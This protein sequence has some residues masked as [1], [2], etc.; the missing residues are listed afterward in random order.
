MILCINN[1]TCTVS[2][3]ITILFSSKG[4]RN[5]LT[6]CWSST[7]YQVLTRLIYMPNERLSTITSVTKQVLQS[8]IYVSCSHNYHFIWVIQQT[9]QM[10]SWSII[11][12]CVYIICGYMKFK[13]LSVC[14]YRRKKKKA[15]KHLDLITTT[16]FTT[17]TRDNNHQQLLNQ[18][19]I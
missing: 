12:G 13:I 15:K 14:E 9:K 7:H 1:Q 2:S 4:H 17:K 3:I 19:E 11:F 16:T 6:V 10:S 18:L 8:S 5:I